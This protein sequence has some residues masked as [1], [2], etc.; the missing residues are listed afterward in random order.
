MI[1][2]MQHWKNP[3]IFFRFS[4]LIWEEINEI[5]NFWINLVKKRKYCEKIENICEHSIQFGQVWTVS[6]QIG[7]KPFPFDSAEGGARRANLW[8]KHINKRREFHVG[9]PLR[10]WDSS[11]WSHN[12]CH[13]KSECGKNSDHKMF[14]RRNSAVVLCVVSLKEAVQRAVL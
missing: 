7:R 1:F 14:C 3:M 9:F 2:S 5:S 6:A 4:V 10:S 11:N 13:Q 8:K 12:C